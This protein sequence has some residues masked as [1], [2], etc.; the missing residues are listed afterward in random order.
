MR[1]MIVIAFKRSG[2]FEPAEHDNVERIGPAPGIDADFEIGHARHNITHSFKR[3]FHQERIFSGA[4]PQCHW[5]KAPH[6]D[7][8]HRARLR[9]THGER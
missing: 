2:T 5:M 9:M 4:A 3:S 1:R 7:M 6:D 8:A